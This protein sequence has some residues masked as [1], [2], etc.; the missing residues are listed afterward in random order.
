[1]YLGLWGVVVGGEFYL[2]GVADQLSLGGDL[3]EI[4]LLEDERVWLVRARR[5]VEAQAK[6]MLMQGLELMVSKRRR[7]REDQAVTINICIMC[8]GVCVCV[9]G[10]CMCVHVHG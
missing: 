7:S 1:M 4:R 10:V 5:E 6:R 2:F 8:M 9:H 3:A